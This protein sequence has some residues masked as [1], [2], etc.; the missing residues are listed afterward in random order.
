DFRM[1]IGL[2]EQQVMLAILRLHPNAYGVSV[3]EQIAERTGRTHSFGAIYAALDRLEEK[4][5]I[6]SRHGQPTAESGGRRKLHFTLTAPGQLALD[7]SLR[8]I[9]SLRQGLRLKG[10]P[11]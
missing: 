11:A 10:A 9:D 4:G 8:A 1:D 7:Q 2:L 5:F 6:K 3:Q